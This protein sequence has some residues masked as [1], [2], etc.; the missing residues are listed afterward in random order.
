[1][2]FIILLALFVGFPVFGIIFLSILFLTMLYFM[3]GWFQTRATWTFGNSSR[4]GVSAEHTWV[5][6]KI[7]FVFHLG[8]DLVFRGSCKFKCRHRFINLKFLPCFI[9]K[10][11]HCRGHWK[12]WLSSTL[13]LF[14]L[15]LHYKWLIW[16]AVKFM[17]VYFY[18]TSWLESLFRIFREIG[19][20]CCIVLTLPT[21]AFCRPFLP[22]F[23]HSP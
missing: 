2:S 6:R 10:Q 4:I 8:Y 12:A 16:T 9:S 19:Q 20:L 1:M 23:W 7:W 13:E 5:S 22:N 14:V 18:L 15:M 11:N 17:A 3:P 21:L